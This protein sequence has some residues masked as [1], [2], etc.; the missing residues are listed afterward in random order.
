M[1][2]WSPE[3]KCAEILLFESG[4][5]TYS[6]VKFKGEMEGFHLNFLFWRSGPIKYTILLTAEKST[7]LD[8]F[9]SPPS[10][11]MHLPADICMHMEKPS[12]YDLSSTQ[13][14]YMECPD[15]LLLCTN[16]TVG[17]LSGLIHTPW[18]R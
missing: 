2:L 17:L 8:G 3:R 4:A 18:V 15:S 11:I 16:V 13:L 7:G 10:L 6:G 14:M 5:S 12:R 9:H 1:P